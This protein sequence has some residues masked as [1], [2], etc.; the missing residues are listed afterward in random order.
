MEKIV[1]NN[2]FSSNIF[3]QTQIHNARETGN[4]CCEENKKYYFITG[5]SLNNSVM[6]V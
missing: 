1:Q 2:R 6:L 3:Q 5:G 4:D